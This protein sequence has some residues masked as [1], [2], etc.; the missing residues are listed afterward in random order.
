MKCAYEASEGVAT[1]PQVFIDGRRLG[2]SDAL[3]AFLA[4]E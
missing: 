2:G 1:T 3:E 4:Q